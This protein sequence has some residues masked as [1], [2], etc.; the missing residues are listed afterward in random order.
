MISRP[1]LSSLLLRS[2]TV[3]SFCCILPISN[4]IHS[5]QKWFVGTPATEAKKRKKA[6]AKARK[7]GTK[8]NAPSPISSTVTIVGDDLAGSVTTDSVVQDAD[9]GEGGMDLSGAS[10][11][12]CLDA[13][14]IAGSD[15][16]LSEAE[17]DEPAS[18]KTKIL[19]KITAYIDIISPARSAKVKETT[20]TRGPFFFT[21][22]TTHQEFL[23]LLATCADD[24]NAVP[25]VVSINQAQLLWKLNVPA[26]DKKKPLANGQGYQ[27]MI[28]ILTN[29][30]T[31]KSKDSTITLI[32]PPLLK[33]IRAV[34]IFILCPLYP[35]VC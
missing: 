1:I 5:V 10:D 20:I 26:N 25:N 27:A 21:T 4:N 22:E 15:A 12:G 24:G 13:V 35:H 19:P 14:S 17:D 34:C 7:K 32:M 29:R 28:G 33:N 23:R 3:G 11:V 18:K 2:L 31:E 9:F 8:A 6:P 30:L 16:G